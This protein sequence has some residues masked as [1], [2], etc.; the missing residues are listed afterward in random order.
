MIELSRSV[1]ISVPLTGPDEAR[2]GSNT[3]AEW[4][5]VPGIFA[6]YELEVRC[7]G[8]ADATTG[9]L[10]NIAEI[11][12]A[13]RASAR[14]VL[15][16]SVRSRPETEPA[17]LLGPIL[18]AL[19]PPLNG[20]VHSVRW[21]LSPYYSVTMTASAPDSV[22]LRETFEFAAAHRLNCASL[23]EA[24]NRALFGKCNN[25]GGHGHNYRVEVAFAVP[26]RGAEL[27][28]SRLDLQKT[29]P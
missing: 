28:V 9:Y 4:P 17:A 25:P 7:R 11:D 21:R 16:D 1:R 10:L 13:V 18:E 2:R 3:F 19:N 20:T 15:E 26:L 5:T 23:T 12:A 24:E 29:G 6:W 8:L 27:A 14:P 22:L